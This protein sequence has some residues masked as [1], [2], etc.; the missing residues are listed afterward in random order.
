M[1]VIPSGSKR[2]PKKRSVAKAGAPG[3]AGAGG[4]GGGPPPQTGS[5]PPSPC[6]LPPAGGGER[7]EERVARR[8]FWRQKL[9]PNFPRTALRF[10][11]SGG[12]D[13][14]TQFR[15]RSGV[16]LRPY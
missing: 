16:F 1:A 15:N 3:R 6:P 7:V 13:G 4:G 5:S 9:S 11:G 12:E 2:S 10:R 14:C 8:K